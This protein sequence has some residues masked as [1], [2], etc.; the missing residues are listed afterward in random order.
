MN[1][2]HQY[3]RVRADDC[4]AHGSEKFWERLPPHWLNMRPRAMSPA[5][6]TSVVGYAGI[7]V[8]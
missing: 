1:E 2:D 3:V 5:T 8:E 7:I 6:T 4:D